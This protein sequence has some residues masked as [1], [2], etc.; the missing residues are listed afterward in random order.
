MLIDRLNVLKALVELIRQTLIAIAIGA[1][2]VLAAA[3]AIKYPDKIAAYFKNSEISEINIGVL[4]LTIKKSEEAIAD[5]NQIIAN[6]IGHLRAAPAADNSALLGELEKLQKQSQE[7]VAEVKKVQTEVSAGG[8]SKPESTDPSSAKW[9]VIFSSYPSN[10]NTASELASAQS[11]G[12]GEAKLYL[13][14]G[15]YRGVLVF[16]SEA[17]A[18]EALNKID[19]TFKSAY[20]RNLNEWCG[21][22]AREVE[23]TVRC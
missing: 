16:S 14:K 12:A 2:L 22:D 13:N 8:T 23:G 15:R 11:L 19:D 17:Q 9:G 4:K 3:V 6:L 10:V 18:R 1:V 7:A 20:I 5:T 21:T